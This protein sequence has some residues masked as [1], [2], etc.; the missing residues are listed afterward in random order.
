MNN[1]FWHYDWSGLVCWSWFGPHKKYIFQHHE[2]QHKPCVLLTS[3]VPRPTLGHS[4]QSGNLTRPH[5]TVNTA[6]LLPIGRSDI[7][8]L[9]RLISL[10]VSLIHRDGA[11][12]ENCERNKSFLLQE[13]AGLVH[14][15]YCSTKRRKQRRRRSKLV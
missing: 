4:W 7:I 11:E 12:V 9:L 14:S 5:L 3:Q 2:A 15:S 13:T 10:K 1:L 6:A 8:Q